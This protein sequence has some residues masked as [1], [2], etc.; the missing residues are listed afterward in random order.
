M[1]DIL[2]QGT[3]AFRHEQLKVLYLIWKKPWMTVGRDTYIHNILQSF[4]LIPCITD[5]RY[6]VLS[7]EEL[8][9]NDW[10]V[11]LLELGTLSF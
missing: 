7:E 11:L 3:K 1:R 4:G 5:L 2:D 6:P 10:D 8:L 9:S